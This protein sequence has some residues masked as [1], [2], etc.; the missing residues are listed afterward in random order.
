MKFRKTRVFLLLIQWVCIGSLFAAEKFSYHTEKIEADSDDYSYYQP[1][2]SNTTLDNIGGVE[3]RNVILLI[4]DGMGPNHVALTRHIALGPDKKL[5]MER[6]PVVGLVRTYSADT[7]ITDSAAGGTALACGI[8]TNNGMI[9]MSP[10]GIAYS[11]ILELLHQKGFRTGLVATSEVSHATPASFASHV[12][13][14]KSQHEIAAQLFDNR[15]DVLF[16][17]GRKYWP[18]KRLDEAIANGYQFAETRDQMLALKPGP[19]IALFAD[20][21]LKTIAP[22][23]MLDE[24]AQTA[25]RLLSSKS[26]EWFAPQ[27]KFFLMIEGSQID[28]A[29]HGNDTGALIRQMLLF[30]MAVHKAIEFA[31]QDRKTLVIVTA[32][33]ETGGLVLETGMRNKWKI[34][35]DWKGTSHTAGDVPLYA[36]GPGSEH[37]AGVMDNTEIPKRIA[38][39]MGIKDF[40]VVRQPSPETVE[41]S[42]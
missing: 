27:P 35:A 30:D 19:S 24:M 34:N 32:D 29:A 9:G 38:E 18:Q 2:S 42:E 33:H 25:I 36:F 28:W 12:K 13:S 41:V 23:P 4:G 11:S 40:P 10:D 21:G 14:R 16:G 3:I 20:E 26:E 7:L 37:F 5:H 17:G 22:E 1:P 15:V 31:K 6:L 39:L 8:K